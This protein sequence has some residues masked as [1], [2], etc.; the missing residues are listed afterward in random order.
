MPEL[1]T[2]AEVAEHLR[3]S[4]RQVRD[5]IKR[6]GIEA[7]RIG[8]TGSIRIPATAVSDLLVRYIPP[9]PTAA[10]DDVMTVG[11]ILKAAGE[12]N[13]TRSAVLRAASWLRENGVPQTR[14]AGVKGFTIDRST[15]A[16]LKQA[17]GLTP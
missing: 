6:G 7:M 12:E 9:Q 4:Q 15:I 11:D 10:P 5:L 1:L 3:L 16:G 14:K 2:V 13:P 17:L 8:A